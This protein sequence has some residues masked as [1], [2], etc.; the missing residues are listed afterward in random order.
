MI[1]VLLSTY[2][3]ERYI[4]K[5]MESLLHQSC[6]DFKIIVRDDGSKD[7]TLEII[8]KIAQCNDKVTIIKGQNVGFIESFTDLV[9]YAYQNYSDA[10]YFA[11]CDQDDLWYP[12]KLEK[13]VS[14]LRS[15]DQNIPLL[16][17]CNSDLIDEHDCLI[18]DYRTG[19]V[20]ITKENYLFNVDFQGCSMCFN[21]KALEIYAM[22]PP[23]T[24]CHDKWMSMICIFL[25]VYIH[26]DEHLFGYRIH[27][28]NAIGYNI[29]DGIKEKIRAKINYWFGE[30]VSFSYYLFY[31]TFESSL[32]DANRKLLKNRI[33]YRTSLTSKLWLMRKREC[34]P[35]IDFKSYIKYC[36]HLIF[37]RF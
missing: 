26:S 8:T 35:R 21:R 11:F 16:F 15:Y 4:K 36:I 17:S 10:D 22:H 31:Q 34:C 3:G 29:N 24:I 1:V 19:S 6:V 30:N 18:G 14:V 2:N 23:K 12:K 7:N 27:T 32:T 20:K 37:N 33:N 28:G 25:G 5:Q 9:L 13:S